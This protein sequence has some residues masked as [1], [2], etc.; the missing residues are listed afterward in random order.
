[1]V[2][3]EDYVSLDESLLEFAL[4]LRWRQCPNAEYFLRSIIEHPTF[5]ANDE[6][7]LERYGNPVTPLQAWM[8]ELQECI[9]EKQDHYYFTLLLILLE[10]GAD[11][12][13]ETETRISPVNMAIKALGI[14]QRRCGERSLYALVWHR[15][16]ALLQNPT[17]GLQRWNDLNRD[18]EIFFFPGDFENSTD[19]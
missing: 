1:M 3:G 7:E 16:M 14:S 5:K 19:E 12:N 17:D 10:R 18:T 4:S 15:V 2:L 8:F 6:T 13:L 11:P 9:D